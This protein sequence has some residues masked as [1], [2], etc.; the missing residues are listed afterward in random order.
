MHYFYSDIQVNGGSA[1][2]T[3]VDQLHH[4]RDV[5]RLK[6]G[7]RITVCDS[8]GIEY[9]CTISSLDRKQA[10]LAIEERTAPAYGKD[11]LAVACALPKLAGMDEIVDKL[12]QLDTDVIIP[13]QTERT[14]IRLNRADAGERIETRLERWRKISRSAAEQ[15]HRR[16]LPQIM[17]LMDFSAVLKLSKGYG[18]KLIP[19]LEG[20]RSPL[21]EISRLPAD[22][23]T[24]VL[25]GPE[26]DF[27][28]AEID[29]AIRAGFMAISLG[30]TV[31]RVDTAAIAVAGFLRL[32]RQSE[33]HTYT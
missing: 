13:L 26:G 30:A 23:G 20:K 7:Q 1:L 5:L 24:I 6:T 17:P 33:G 15:S 14:V 10:G 4:L 12:T 31:L 3:D 9:L 2:I 25:I 8:T 22:S 18:L 27:T 16:S 19:T 29:E 11:R 28:S 32:I 21:K